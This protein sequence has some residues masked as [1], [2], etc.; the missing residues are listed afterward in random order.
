MRPDLITWP[1]EKVAELKRLWEVERLTAQEIG[2]RLG[3]SKYSIVGK[4]RRVG[5][6]KRASPIIRGRTPLQKKRER[7]LAVLNRPVEPPPAGPAV[8]A[9]AKPPEPKPLR[10]RGRWLGERKGPERR[11]TPGW[12]PKACQWIAGEP[13]ADDACKCGEPVTPG[14]PYCDAHWARSWNSS[15]EESHGLDQAGAAA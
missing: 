4:A 9:A 1:E 3:M 11:A 2:R 8:E 10:G 14:R 13:S 7:M 15:K 12:R 6:T 5:C